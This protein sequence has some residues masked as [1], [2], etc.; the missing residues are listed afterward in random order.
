MF[1][2]R[3]AAK[4]RNLAYLLLVLVVSAA[5]ASS[6]APAKKE[7]IIGSTTS[8]QD[9]GLFSELIPAFK[10]AYPDYNPKVVA[11][12]SGEALELG[13][14]GDADVLLVHSPKDE[15]RFMKEGHGTKRL[16]AM[17][18]Y[19]A[20]VGPKSDPAGIFGVTDPI[21][22]MSRIAISGSPFISRGDDSG[23]YKK[24]Q[25][26]W[27]AAQVKPKGEWYVKAGQGM[28]EVLT[29]ASEKQGYTVTDLAT[30]LAAADRLQ[31]ARLTEKAPLLLNRYSVI[32]PA[33]TANPG[34]ANSF[35]QWI[36]SSEGR[37]VIGLFGKKKF[38]EPLFAPGWPQAEDL[39]GG[40]SADANTKDSG[41]DAHSPQ[42]GTPD[43]RHD[44]PDDDN[45][46]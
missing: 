23:T 35:A 13:K 18:N 34:G 19:F 27:K 17:H 45:S 14:R 21:E 39:S 3:A 11:V 32:V 28:S 40:A 26:L 12:G 15:E 16:P 25:A 5:I 9:S 8:I 2:T 44:L 1:H 30:F 41:G 36:T 22:S 42:P 31:L 33:R 6:C 7:L 46:K 29:I 43:E 20:I 24:E 37:T 4:V 10:K 38:G